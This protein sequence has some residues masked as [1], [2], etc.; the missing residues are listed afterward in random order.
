MGL[1][2]GL[3]PGRQLVGKAFRRGGKF[4]RPCPAPSCAPNSW[5][6]VSF[7]AKLLSQQ[8]ISSY[9]N[10]YA[11]SHSSVPRIATFNELPVTA[12]TGRLVVLFPR[13]PPTF[14]LLPTLL[15]FKRILLQK[16][17]RRPPS[18]SDAPCYQG[19]SGRIAGHLRCVHAVALWGG[20]GVRAKPISVEAPLKVS[21]AGAGVCRVPWPGER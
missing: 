14:Q 6:F 10:H 7:V 11:L 3:K 5:T 21:V 17:A 2:G 8:V 12:I 13:A 1:R 9:T 20:R 15:L 4:E 18:L 19:V 16:S